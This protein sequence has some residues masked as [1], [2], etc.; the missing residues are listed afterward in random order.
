MRIRN[1]FLYSHQRPSHRTVLR[2]I[3]MSAVVATCAGLYFVFGPFQ[4]H[5]AVTFVVTNANDSGPGSLRQAILDANANPGL[6][7]IAFNIAGAS[8]RIQPVGGLPNITDPVVID[9]ST[10]PGF[11]GTPIIEL[12]GS[13][14]ASLGLFVNAPG[15]TVRSLVINGFNLGGI[16]LGSNATGSSVE[17]CYVGTDVTGKIAIPNGGSGVGVF[18]PQ[19]VIG[20]TTASKRNVISGNLGAGVEVFLFCCDHAAMGGNIIHGNYIGVTATGDAALGNQREGIILNTNGGDTRLLGTLIGGTAPGAGNVISGNRFDGIL[21]GSFGTIET[22]IQG[23]RIGTDVTG[24]FAIPNDG[25]GVRIDLGGNH[26][27]GGSAPGARNIISGNGRNGSGTGRGDGIRV[28]SGS[29]NRIQGNLIGT[30]ATG[31]GALPNLDN[32]ISTTGSSHKIGGTA[33]GEGNVIAFNGANGIRTTGS[34]AFTIQNSIRGNSI[35]SNGNFGSP[36]NPGMGIDL[37]AVGPNAND[38][39]DTDTGPNFLQNFPII[40]SVTAG[41]GTTNVKGSL[42]SSASKPFSLDFFRNSACDTSAHGEG[43]H[44][45]GSTTVTTDASGNA[46][47]D[48][49][50]SVSISQTEL[51][52]ATATDEI[53][54]TSEFSPCKTVGTIGVSVGD[55]SALEGNSGSKSFSFPVVL[56]SAAM[57]EVTVTFNTQD[58]TALAAANDYVANLGTVKIPAGQTS[59]DIVVQVNGDLAVEDDEVFFVKLT[60]AT[61]ASILDSQ[62]TGTILNDDEIRLILEESGPVVGQAAALDWVLFLRDPFRVVN[63]LNWLSGS[64]NPNTAV[65]VFAENLIL[66]FFEA[67]SAVGVT[68]VDINNQT[69][70]LS[71]EQVSPVTVSGLNL[72]Q[73]VFRLPNG[74]APGTCTVKLVYKGKVSNTATIRI[75]P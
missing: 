36:F 54:N 6:D 60:A 19:N 30:T 45:I 56:Q 43:E 13:L 59:V 39:G 7:S 52:T 27:I 50:F 25:D 66:P 44:L 5:A 35:H 23:N 20:G 49:T 51:V 68:L 1:T 48:V 38:P 22:T 8:R 63:P 64:A 67:P 71:A 61:N 46:T 32:G 65:V 4:T 10:Q 74:L 72:S 11:A 15:S 9:G 31:T 28:S 47:F 3:A 37:G 17:G 42:N 58:G 21:L 16:S 26:I 24:M 14:S 29:G 75:V 73:V 33:A 2:A 57:Q 34:G 18:S 55:V 70:S 53:D 40:T 41:A 62:A 12:N 69:F